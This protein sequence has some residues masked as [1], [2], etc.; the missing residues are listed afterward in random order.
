VEIHSPIAI[1]APST[2]LSSDSHSASDLVTFSMDE[3]TRDEEEEM[4]SHHDGN[5]TGGEHDQIHPL[6]TA[7]GGS[8]AVNLLA[9]L[10]PD[11]YNDIVCLSLFFSLSYSSPS[12]S[13]S[14]S[15]SPHFFHV[16]D[17]IY[18]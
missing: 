12:F 4:S 7:V 8:N 14:F 1:Q 9:A 11:W 2:G 15:L 5:T 16:G 6:T 18:R 3:S 17:I 13:L 10:T